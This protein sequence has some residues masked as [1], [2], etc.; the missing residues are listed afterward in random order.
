MTQ[1][2]TPFVL[3]VPCTSRLDRRVHQAHARGPSV[4]E[5]LG[6]IEAFQIRMRNVAHDLAVH[7]LLADGIRD[8]GRVHQ[9]DL[10][11]R[12]DLRAQNNG[13]GTR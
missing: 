5:K 10:G 13:N 9:P 3:H 6:R 7:D 8:L 12:V 11:A 1:A 2:R 4:R